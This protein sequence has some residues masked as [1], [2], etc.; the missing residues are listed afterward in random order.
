MEESIP[1]PEHERDPSFVK[2]M[3]IP[4][5]ICLLAALFYLYD[6]FLRVTPSVMI[7]PL[8]HD[9]GVGAT[10]IG[11][12]SAFYYYAYTP[13]QIPSGIIIDKYSI[14]KV[15]TLSLLLCVIGTFIF[16]TFINLPA[17]FIGRILM[18]AGSAFAFVG[19]LKLA[20]VW[21]PRN[22]FALFTG[23]TTALGT[24]GAVFA[25]TILS[26]M[27]HWWG[28]R[29]SLHITVGIG[30]IL[31][32]LTFFIIRDRPAWVTRMPQSYLT[33]KR[34]WGR[35]VALLKSWR[36]WMNGIVGCLLFLPVSVFASLWG[37][38]F[39]IKSY[40][41]SAAVGATATSLIFIGTAIG[42]PIVGWISDRIKSRRIPIFIGTVATTILSMV[43]I[44]VPGLPQF[45]ILILL[46][47]LG[48]CVAPQILVFAIAREI[49]PPRSTGISTATTNFLVTIGGAV[50]QP[51]IGFLLDLHWDGTKT[52]SGI[53]SYS[54]HDYRLALL[55]LPAVLFLSFLITF[56]IP[57]TK[58][59]KLYTEREE[60]YDHDDER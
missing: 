21:L 39:I 20:A 6:F 45:V 57:K 40:H 56:T 54:M 17:A 42:S 26:R 31:T 24:F 10:E 46:F 55:V 60:Y 47:L 53:P 49:S 22:Q 18:G 51:L 25:D 30:L 2:G 44:Y 50:F 37:V 5:I 9:Y 27:V 7:H 52:A 19:A 28:W 43:L 13:L 8:M 11:F 38:A 34:I 29:F 32:V 35:V 23:L 15:L 14:R 59:H 1:S 12:I 36:F 48:L 4:W 16:V 3:L 58:C 41:L 33:W